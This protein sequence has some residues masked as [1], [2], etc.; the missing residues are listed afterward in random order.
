MNISLEEAIGLL[1]KW[2]ASETPLRIHVSGQQ[3]DLQGVVGQV[4]GTVI[5]V[6][7]GPRELK[8]DVRGSE[9]N[10][11]SRRPTSSSGAYLVCELPN[12]TRCSFRAL[13]NK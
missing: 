4:A 12:G 9:F 1:E 8:L 7:V 6:V 2:R 13:P 11:D 5:T 3:G 10:G